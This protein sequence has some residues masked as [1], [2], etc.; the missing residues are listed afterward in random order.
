[1]QLGLAFETKEQMS[2]AVNLLL[3]NCPIESPPCGQTLQGWADLKRHVRTDHGREL[4]DLCISN[5]KIFADEHIA[6]A[7]SDLAKHIDKDHAP[8][9]FCRHL[10]RKAGIF[11]DN[12]ILYKHCRD[13]HEECFI[14]VR[15][16]VRHQYHLNYDRLVS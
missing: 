12:D 5:K 10:P 13:E 8:C 11:Y 9:G 7:P 2:A 4:C 1:M 3:F 14:C 16:G 6:Y 15:Q